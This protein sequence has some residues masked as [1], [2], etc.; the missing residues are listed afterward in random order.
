MHGVRD[1]LRIIVILSLLLGSLYGSDERQYPTLE[2]YFR[3]ANADKE[4]VSITQVSRPPE[5]ALSRSQK[6]ILT[7]IA[8]AVVI[9]GWGYAQ[10]G[11]FTQPFNRKKEGYLEKDT[12]NGGADKLGHLYSAYLITRLLAPL[13]EGWGYERNDA[14][15]YAA[16][17]S[18]FLT[19]GVMEFGDGT[20]PYGF[21]SEDVVMDSIGIGIGYLW[22]RYPALA[23]M[24]DLRVEWV[25]DFSKLG[26]DTDF[27]T[28]YEHMKH[29]VAIKASGVAA[30]SETPLKYAELHFGYFGRNF[31]DNGH[32][33]DYHPIPVEET[34]RYF[35]IAVGLNLSFI[36]EPAI[37]GYSKVFNYYQMPYTYLPYNHR[38]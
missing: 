27:T 8:G 11:Y 17:S 5:K 2:E 24:I 21:S 35:Y 33:G 29:L 15:L 16:L 28:D 4:A 7:N 6:V 20:S 3:Q 19:I 34:E 31:H 23:R 22:H 26:K 36:L 1:I 14:A 32:P 37:G 25:P 10:W 18:A 30:L 38:L 9:G 12:S 13:Y